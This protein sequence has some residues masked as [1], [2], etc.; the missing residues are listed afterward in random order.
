MRKLATITAATS[1]ALFVAAHRTGP[2]PAALTGQVSRQGRDG[3]RCRERQ[4]GRGTITV[5][6]RRKGQ[7][8]FPAE[9]LEPGITRS[10]PSAGYDLDGPKA[11]DVA[12]GRRPPPTSLKPTRNLTRQLTNA[13]G[14]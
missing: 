14:C 1:A 9:R 7:Y 8:N 5:A 10:A 3:R 4:E 13:S 12:P 2:A 11:A 6:A